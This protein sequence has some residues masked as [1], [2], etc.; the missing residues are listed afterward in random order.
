VDKQ[1]I[2]ASKFQ[3]LDLVCI[4]IAGLLW[5]HQSQVGWWPLLIALLP[6]LIRLGSGEFPFQRTPF[7]LYILIFLITAG[8]GLWAAYNRD[9]AWLKFWVLIGGIGTYFALARQPQSNLVTLL[10]FLG[11][12]GAALTLEFLFF[13]DWVVHPAD[14]GFI[15]AIGLCWMDYRPDLSGALINPNKTAGLLAVLSPYVIAFGAIVWRRRR[16]SRGSLLLAAVTL[17]MISFGLLMTSSRAAWGV[18]IL[19]FGLWL[20]WLVYQFFTRN[21]KISAQLRGLVFLLLVGGVILGLFVTNSGVIF[22]LAD[23]LPGYPSTASRY[24]L[25]RNT[26]YL[27]GDY[28]FT[29]GGLGAFPGLFSQ[30]V[31]VI[32]NLLFSYSHNF[33]LDIALEQGLL[34]L[35]SVIAVLIGAG[36]FLVWRSI[37]AENRGDQKEIGAAVLVSLVILLLHGMLDDPLYGNRGSLL[38]FLTPGIAVAYARDPKQAARTGLQSQKKRKSALW[39]LMLLVLAIILTVVMVLPPARGAWIA[40]IGAVR[41]SRVELDGFPSNEWQEGSSQASLL[42]G[43]SK[44]REDFS[45]ALT[46]AP[47]EVTAL[48]RSGLIAMLGGDFPAAIHFLEKAFEHSPQHRGIQKNL[49]YCYTWLGEY[50]HAQ[51]YLDKIPEAEQELEVYAWWWKAQGRDELSYNARKMRAILNE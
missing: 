48:H 41:M 39:Y 25:A 8:I 2:R 1:L 31:M 29:G 18:V 33:Y 36:F 44:A 37:R 9:A 4:T 13:Y 45:Q 27:I 34:G 6:W 32:P 24:E 38:L 7:D 23:R 3:Y 40:N 12:V 46:I 19:G 35:I 47:L 5:T 15:N 16:T 22:T 42:D 51:V 43:L 28:P 14:F 50:N 11:I 49:G 26:I 30:Y 20:L 17:G 21:W 10:G